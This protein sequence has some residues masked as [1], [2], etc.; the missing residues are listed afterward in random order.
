M[1]NM[2]VRWRSRAADSI[3][4]VLM[5]LQDAIT[6][7]AVGAARTSTRLGSVSAQIRR[8]NDAVDEMLGTAARLNED[9]KRI[10][11]SS[12]HTLVAA[13]EMNKLSTAGRAL[14]AQ[15]AASS[16]QLQAQMQ[17]TVE[18]IDRLVRSVQAITHVSK[19]IE[20][21]ARQTRL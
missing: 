14:S 4:S 20:D 19:V 5:S 11:Q 9:I 3:R 2:L 18:R 12:T 21:I 16:E 13:Q 10:A 1:A 6:R 8:S 7:A 15:G 17:Q